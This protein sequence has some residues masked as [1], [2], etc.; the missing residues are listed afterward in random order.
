MLTLTGKDAM[1]FRNILPAWICVTSIGVLCTLEEQL[2]MHLCTDMYDNAY[3]L[4]ID[5]LAIFLCYM[6]LRGG[7]P[8]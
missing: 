1:H 6:L 7:V 4:S 5:W 8:A 3:F 2:L